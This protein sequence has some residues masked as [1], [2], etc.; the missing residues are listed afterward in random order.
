MNIAVVGQGYVG[1]PLAIAAVD[2]GHH[3][4]GI[5]VDLRL[6][7]KLNNGTSPIVDI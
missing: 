2:A 5:D 3:V 7:E 6:I 1:L 4:L